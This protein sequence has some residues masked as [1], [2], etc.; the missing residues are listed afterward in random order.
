MP[1]DGYGL[2]DQ[3]LARPGTTASYPISVRRLTVL[4][5]TSFTH[6]LAALRLSFATLHHRQVV[7][8]PAPPGVEHAQHTKKG[9]L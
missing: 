1:L 9:A 8:G 6:C 2:R 3:L 7:G 5:R 4:L